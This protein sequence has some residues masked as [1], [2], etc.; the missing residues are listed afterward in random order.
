MAALKMDNAFCLRTGLAFFLNHSFMAR[1]QMNNFENQYSFD[2]LSLLL[3]LWLL[4]LLLLLLSFLLLLLWLW[5]FLWWWWSSLSSWSFLVLVVVPGLRGDNPARGLG[6]LLLGENSFASGGGGSLRISGKHVSWHRVFTSD[7]QATSAP[8]FQKDAFSHW[9]QS[10]SK[11]KL[12]VLVFIL[13]GLT[14]TAFPEK[15]QQ[16]TGFPLPPQKKWDA[17]AIPVV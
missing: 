1:K 10:K 11:N 2:Q 15:M 17:P 9:K 4:L 13:W 7:K 5:L 8:K 14:S 16:Q 12:F 3:W 6:V